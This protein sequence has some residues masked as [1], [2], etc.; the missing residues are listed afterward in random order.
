VEYEELLDRALESIPKVVSE[1]SRFQIPQAEVTIAGSRTVVKNLRA[2]ASALNREAGHLAKFLLRELAAAGALRESQLV[3]QG[4]F[5]RDTIQERVKRYADEFVIC[6][7]CK[8]PDTRL[9]RVERIPVIRCE[10]CG[11]RNPVRSV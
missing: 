2:M 1:E 7:E 6:R 4:R 11:A 8:K 10:A 5:P 3:L 9:E